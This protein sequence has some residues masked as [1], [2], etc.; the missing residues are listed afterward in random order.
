MPS[1]QIASKTLGVL[2]AA[3][4]LA[5]A[6]SVPDQPEA[7]DLLKNV[8]LTYRAMRTFSAKSTTV[9]EIN[10]SNMQ[11]KIETPMT[12]TGDSSGKMRMET[13]S[14]GGSLTVFDGSVLW[15]YISSLNKYMKMPSSGV[16]SGPLGGGDLGGR[17]VGAMGMSNPGTDSLFG[18]QSVDSNVKEAKILRSEKLEANGTGVDCWVV[19]VAYESSGGQASSEQGAGAP[20]VDLTRTKTLWVDKAHY[21]V[22]RDDSSGK[23]TMPGTGT[24]T[25]TKQTIKFDSITVDQPVP[26]G[27]FTFTPPPGATEMDLSS[28]IPKTLPTK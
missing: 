25:E 12:I 19:F 11:T 10:N 2:L 27:T 9:I 21:L 8:A 6:Q 14:M 7:L 20:A 1:A 23:M 26:E 18:Y 5:A 17:A 16:S 15:M 3:A 22:Y 24:P 13:T 28:L 4:I